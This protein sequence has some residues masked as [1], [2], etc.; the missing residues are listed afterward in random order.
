MIKGTLSKLDVEFSD[1]VVYRLVMGEASLTLND[2]LGRTLSINFSGEIYCTA[3]G[4]R[5][6]TSFSQGFCFP[7]CQKLAQCDLCIVRP[8]TCH[9]EQGTCREP[10]WGMTHCMQPHYVYLANS[11]GLKVGITRQTQIP[12][13]WIDQGAQ[14]ALTIF[15]VQT[16]FQS[17]LLEACIAKHVMDKTDW[18]K[19]LKGD[20][21]ALDL[22][23]E[24]DRLTDRLANDLGDLRS[25]FGELAI[26]T[27]PDSKTVTIRYPFLN[28]P[29]AIKALNLEKT[30]QI[31]GK[32]LGIKGQY[33]LFD[34]GVLNIRKYTGYGVEVWGD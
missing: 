12:Q 20:A 16:R 9:F 2:Y 17:G 1:P 33:L 11:S 3:C 23:A 18:R 24:R 5:T 34:S 25:R 28:Y 32:L 29:T 10:Q 7:C 22:V 14:Q 8:E 27:L 4:R 6:K 15:K 31:S 30:P 13:R 26:A 19:M 21:P